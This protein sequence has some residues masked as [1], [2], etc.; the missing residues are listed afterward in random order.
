[1]RITRLLIDFV[2]PCRYLH[3]P[4]FEVPRNLLPWDRMVRN[5]TI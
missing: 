3:S 1:M 5:L 2:F 4:E